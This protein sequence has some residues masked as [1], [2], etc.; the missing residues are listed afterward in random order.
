MTRSRHSL[1]TSRIKISESH[2]NSLMTPHYIIPQCLII[3]SSKKQNYKPHT[4]QHPQ[5]ITG[6]L[7]TKSIQLHINSFSTIPCQ[8]GEHP[9]SCNSPNPFPSEVFLSFPPDSCKML[10]P[11]SHF[12]HLYS[13]DLPKPSKDQGQN[14]FTL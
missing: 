4:K 6:C 3:H 11:A 5:I 2:K 7:T 13:T 1:S 9:I 8:H 14:I 12:S 10:N